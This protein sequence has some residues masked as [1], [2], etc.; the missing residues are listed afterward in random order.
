MSFRDMA[1]VLKIFESSRHISKF[2]T[3]YIIRLKH[4]TMRNVERGFYICKHDCT[5]SRE[6]IIKQ[7]ASAMLATLLKIS[8]F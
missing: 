6:L 5:C 3:I 8:V 1:L 7:A 2:T 4:E